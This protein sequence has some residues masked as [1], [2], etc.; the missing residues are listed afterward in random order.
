MRGFDN[1]VL[2][3]DYETPAQYEKRTGK[4]VAD[5]TA[6]FYIKKIEGETHSGWLITTT[7]TP[8]FK[9]LKDMNRLLFVVIADPPT[10]PADDW[11]PEEA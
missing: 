8:Y 3:P 1:I 7:D 11:R 4:P 9:F 5:N 2:I 6:V 10:P